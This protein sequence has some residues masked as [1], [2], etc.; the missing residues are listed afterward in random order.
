MFGTLQSPKGFVFTTLFFAALTLVIGKY[1]VFVLFLL[2]G[3]IVAGE[4]KR[5]FKDRG[6]NPL[7]MHIPS[8]EEVGQGLKRLIPFF[9]GIVGYAFVSFVAYSLTLTSPGEI[10]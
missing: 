1:V 2:F 9:A 5:N 10:R 6:F 7:R 4:Q 8:D 3:L